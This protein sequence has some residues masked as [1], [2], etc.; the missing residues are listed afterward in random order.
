MAEGVKFKGNPLISH[1]FCNNSFSAPPTGILSH[2]FPRLTQPL[3]TV[4]CQGKVAFLLI[5]VCFSLGYY[6]SLKKNG[7]IY[8]FRFDRFK[9]VHRTFWARQIKTIP[10]HRTAHRVMV[11]HEKH[12]YV[13]GKET[14]SGKTGV[15]SG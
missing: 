3:F 12:P 5:N 9:N 15:G 11:K 1:P 7:W 14:L 13:L 4:A 8:R 10:P 2:S 6:N